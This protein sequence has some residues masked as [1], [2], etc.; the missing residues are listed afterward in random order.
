MTTRSTAGGTTPLSPPAVLARSTVR[1][2]AARVSGQTKEA[3][4]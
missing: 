2:P 1:T 4:A 3:T